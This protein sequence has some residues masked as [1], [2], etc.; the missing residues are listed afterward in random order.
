MRSR[1]PPISSGPSGCW[2]SRTGRWTQ[3]QRENTAQ[4]EQHREAFKVYFLAHLQ[5]VRT[6]THGVYRLEGTQ[7][8]RWSGRSILTAGKG[9]R[10]GKEGGSLGNG[11]CQQRS[12]T[13]FGLTRTGAKVPRDRKGTRVPCLSGNAGQG[14]QDFFCLVPVAA[15]GGRAEPKAGPLGRGGAYWQAPPHRA[16]SQRP[17]GS[18]LSPCGLRTHTWASSSRL[19]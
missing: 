4:T 9:G 17:P 5:R 2:T 8:S 10:V 18:R 11:R 19:G 12:P 6:F 1:P 14:Q 13:V 15:L 3:E 16:A 7:G